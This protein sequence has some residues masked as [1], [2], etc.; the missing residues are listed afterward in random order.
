MPPLEPPPPGHYEGHEMAVASEA[1]KVPRSVRFFIV[2]L[3][4]TGA[5]T[6]IGG[7]RTLLYGII[8]EEMI[9]AVIGG[10]MLVLGI[11]TYVVRN[12]METLRPWSWMGALLIEQVAVASGIIS[13][14]QLVLEPGAETAILVVSI[15]HLLLHSFAI[16]YLLRRK[17]RVNFARKSDCST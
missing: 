6:T 10:V 8:Y 2:Y 1:R 11:A 13:V 5:Y 9:T 16:Y 12:G 14:L 3:F 17:F 15:I 4:I 7:L